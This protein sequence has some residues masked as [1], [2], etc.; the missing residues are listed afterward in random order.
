VS[1]EL[2][3]PPVSGDNHHD[4][5][6][7]CSHL[8]DPFCILVW[9]FT[10]HDGLHERLATLL[11]ASEKQVDDQPKCLFQ[12]LVDDGAKLRVHVGLD[13]SHGVL[14]HVIEFAGVLEEARTLAPFSPAFFE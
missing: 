8:R 4:Q 2:Q 14:A 12:R 10:A 5:A 7:A 1:T 13:D 3:D 11:K 9:K 6:P